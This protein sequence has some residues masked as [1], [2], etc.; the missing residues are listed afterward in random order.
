MNAEVKCILI[1]CRLTTALHHLIII[2]DD[3]FGIY[4]DILKCLYLHTLV[5]NFNCGLKVYTGH[6]HSDE[7]KLFF[8]KA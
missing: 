8:Y 5:I 4:I 3:I 6:F 7:V 2:L 1:A